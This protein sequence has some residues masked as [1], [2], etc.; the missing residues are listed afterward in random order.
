MTEFTEFGSGLFE[1][2]AYRMALTGHRN[3]YYILVLFSLL[4]V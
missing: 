2:C 1:M 3:L 4:D